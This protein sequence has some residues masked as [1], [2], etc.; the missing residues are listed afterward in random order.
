MEY[1]QPLTLAEAL[2]LLRD[3][4]APVRLLAGGTDLIPL[5][6]EVSSRPATLIDLKSI[7]ELS[8]LSL[9]ADGSAVIGA[10]LPAIKVTGNQALQRLWPGVVESIAMMGSRQIQSRATLG[11]N[12][13]H[14]SPAADT[15]PA[16]IAAG[17]RCRICSIQGERMVP[18]NEVITSPGKT[19]LR[20]GEI[21]VSVHLPPR[22]PRSADAYLRITPR[23]KMDVA[24]AGVAINLILADDSVVE[25]CTVALGA[26]APVAFAVPEVSEIMTGN[27]IDEAMVARLQRAIR[28]ACRPI[29]DLRGT[30]EYRTHVA[31]VL[32]VRAFKQT[33]QRAL[34]RK[35]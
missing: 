17:A 14:G 16:L 9:H 12:I 11:G 28:Q 31:G 26:V 33:L 35:P 25:R 8:E 22:P 1:R 24:V 34:E 19:C 10:A 18:V 29:D 27:V 2:R 20:Q 13:C 5:M 7:A 21:L 30:A 32:A 15:V 6:R 3:A 4:V 23:Q